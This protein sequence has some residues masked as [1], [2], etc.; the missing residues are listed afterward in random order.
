MNIKQ[1]SDS[2]KM[3]KNPKKSE[4]IWLMSFSDMSLVLMCFF[5]LMLSTMKPDKEK[6]KHVKEGFDSS[7]RHSS[8]TGIKEIEKKIREIIEEKKLKKNAV[9]THSNE[10]LILEFKDGMMFQVGS[11]ELKTQSLKVVRS[12]LSEMSKIHSDYEVKI[13]GHTDDVPFNGS[14]LE[15]WLLSANRGFSIMQELTK[16]GISE[17]RISVTAYAHTKPKVSTEN[18]R[19]RDL[20]RA[21]ASNR[22]VVIRL[23]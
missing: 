12:V 16:L 15:N 8:R 23:E 22:R 11:A 20:A 6:F 13:E 21:R 3:N 5:V 1:P 4:A 18:L 9:V 17:K 2:N 7:N 19:G 14:H 10:G